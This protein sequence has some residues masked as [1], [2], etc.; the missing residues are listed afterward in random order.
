MHRRRAYRGV[1]GAGRFGGRAVLRPPL[2]WCR[3]WSRSSRCVGL[4]GIVTADLPRLY[5][6]RPLPAEYAELLTGRAVVADSLAT[7]DAVVVGV[8]QR[9]DADAVAGTPVRVVSRTGIGYDNVD[10]NG[11][12]ACGVITCNTPAAPSVST[13]EHT[14][15]LMFALTKELPDQLDRAQQGLTGSARSSALELDGRTLGLVGYGR[16]ARRVAAA[17]RAL[18]MTVYAHDPYLPDDPADGVILVGLDELWEV[19]DVVSLHA[20]ALAETRHLVNAVSLAAMRSGVYLVNAARGSLIDQDAL[21]AALDSGH[22]AGAALDV[23]EPEPLPVGH[24][25][26]AHP[27][28][29]ITPHVASSTVAGRRRL[30]E[31]AIDNAINVLT[32]QPAIVVQPTG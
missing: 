3:R 25:L 13:A 21:L 15:A 20:P 28:A 29:I 22:V 2:G 11:L 14:L 5:F 18:G 16:I 12:A 23:T 27:H 8:V 26:L 7:A 17:A 19:S 10:V 31:Q 4:N 30:F 32:G 9:W 6:D 1:V 24:P